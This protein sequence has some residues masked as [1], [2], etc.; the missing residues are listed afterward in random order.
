MY[1]KSYTRKSSAVTGIERAG[2]DPAILAQHE[3]KWGY[4]LANTDDPKL[5]ESATYIGEPEPPKSNVVA[6]PPMPRGVPLPNL[7]DRRKVLR[8]VYRGLKSIQRGNKDPRNL[9]VSVNFLLESAQRLRQS[10]RCA[11]IARA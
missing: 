10:Y 6:F 11:D 4:F 2:L 3:G 1:F 9:P 5:L 7:G 8:S